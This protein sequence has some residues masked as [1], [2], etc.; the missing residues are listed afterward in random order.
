MTSE[1]IAKPSAAG[2]ASASVDGQFLNEIVARAQA[3]G[4]QLTSAM[5]G[6]IRPGRTAETSATHLRVWLEERRLAHVLATKVNDTVI[7]V[8]G[9]DARVE[10]LVAALPASGGTGSPAGPARTVSGF[11]TGRVSRSART[12]RTASDP[13]YWPDAAS[14][15]RA[16]S[17]TEDA[18]VGTN[19]SADPEAPT[20]GGAMGTVRSGDSVCRTGPQSMDGGGRR[21]CRPVRRAGSAP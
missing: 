12:G 10:Q 19:W 20:W 9:A 18:I 7:T 4:R 5:T 15:T 11:A 1:N 3:D 6:T 14:A 8:R 13:G 16:R 2:A 21:R 17:P